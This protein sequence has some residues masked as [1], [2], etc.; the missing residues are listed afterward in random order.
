MHMDKEGNRNLHPLGQSAAPTRGPSPAPSLG[1]SNPMTKD[2]EDKQI[3]AAI[4]ASQGYSQQETGVVGQDGYE[5]KFGPKTQRE[6]KESEWALVP[7]QSAAQ[8]IVPDIPAKARQHEGFEPRI[9]KHL[10]DGDY[11][12]NLIT[13]CNSIPIAREAFLMRDNVKPDY[14]SGP[15]WWRGHGIPMSRVVTADNPSANSDAEKFDEFLTECQ[16][17]MAFLDSSKRSYAS[18]GALTQTEMIKNVPSN[19]NSGTLLELFL[20]T[21]TSASMSKHEDDPDK[22]GQLA[23]LFTTTVDTNAQEGMENNELCVI[24]VTVKPKDG[25]ENA[26]LYEHLDNLLWDTNPDDTDR[27]DNFITK[28][29]EVVVMKASSDDRSASKLG[30]VVPP[31]FH[32][33]KYLEE[34]IGASRVIRENMTKEKARMQKITEIEKKLKTW[35][36]PKKNTEL[37]TRQLLNHTLGHFSGENRKKVDEADK[38]NESSLADL[39]HPSHYA[40]ISA[41]LEKV[42]KTIDDKLEKLAQEKEKSRKVI[43]EMSRAP[44]PGGEEKNCQY[45]YTLRGVATK[46]SVTYVLQP[47][48]QGDRPSSPSLGDETAPEGYCWWRVEYMANGTKI[49]KAKIADHE[50]LRAVELEHNSALLVYASD[51]ATSLEDYYELPAPLQAF[52]ARD[53]AEFEKELKEADDLPS[54]AFDQEMRD[55]PRESIERR[56]SS[57]SLAAV[58]GDDDPPGYDI[59]DRSGLGYHQQEDDEVAEI[60]LS[61]KAEEPSGDTEMIEK[62]HE[63][64]IP[65]AGNSG[66]SDTKIGGTESQDNGMGGNV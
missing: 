7:T 11:T 16:R 33:D 62:A 31:Y 20:Q 54:Y 59:N 3:Q 65:R 48:A 39:P 57:D 29:A 63:P 14:G 45:R 42:V 46:P 37:D 53:N 1:L 10:P 52:V 38:K 32:M 28:P 58:N 51:D 30:L 27:A 36:H 66:A 24:D 49:E 26:E 40:D 47:L 56:G 60:H 2:D 19:S 15:D 61:P 21:W 5:R 25:E 9:L 6:Y 23:N 22:H 18:I 17:L 12:P 55:Q 8:E 64:L 44:L 4:A 34:N 50:V 13:I 43:L 41:K 35:Q